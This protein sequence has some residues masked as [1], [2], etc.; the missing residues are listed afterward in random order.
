[1]RRTQPLLIAV[2]EKDRTVTPYVARA[3]YNRQK[4]ARAPTEFKLFPGLSH[5]LI[6]EPG[7]EGVAQYA[8]EWAART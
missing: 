1:M 4:R 8:I 5:F 6:A 2:G 7:W 3:A